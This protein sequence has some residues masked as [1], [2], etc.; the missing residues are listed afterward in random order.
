MKKNKFLTLLS[1]I[2]LASCSSTN[3]SSTTT[4]TSTDKTTT[5]TNTTTVSTDKESDT[6]LS[7]DYV[8]VASDDTS[9]A[10]E[11]SE[12]SSI[13][14]KL[15][16]TSKDDSLTAQTST[17]VTITEAGSYLFDNSITYKSISIALTSAGS[18][19]LFFDGATISGGKKA[20][21]C[22]DAFTSDITI[23]LLNNSTNTISTTKNSIDITSSL[24]INGSGT[25]NITS[26]GKSCIKS[27]KGVYLGAVTL[28]LA[29][30]ASEEGHGINASYI[31]GDSTTINVT[32]FGKD[33]LHAEMDDAVSEF[34]TSDGYI[35]LKD[36]TMTAS[37]GEGDCLQA[38][39]FINIDGGTYNLTTTAKFIAYGDSTNTT[40]YELENDDFRYTKS[41]DT[42]VKGASENA[43]RSGTYAIANSVRAFKAGGFDYVNAN[44]E[45]IEVETKSAYIQIV[46]ANITLNTQDDA[47]KCK[48]GQ[49]IVENSTFNIS[50]YD[51]GFTSDGPL[52]IN[53]STIDITTSYE[54]LEGSLI[55]IAGSKT[56][57]DIIS[58]DDGINAASDTETDLGI[59]FDN[60]NVTI[61]AD[62]DG[63]DSNGYIY[64]NYGTLTIEGSSEG[65]DSPIDSDGGYYMDGA[66]VLATGSTGMLENPQQDSKQNTLIMQASLSNG[67]KAVLKNGDNEIFTFTSSKTAGV[68]IYSSPLLK[69][70]ST[71]TLYLDDTSS[72][73]ATI[74]STIT[75]IG[76]VQQGPGQGNEPGGRPSGPG[77]S[78]P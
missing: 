41:G 36:V 57:I 27:S 18:V 43:G 52:T 14:S 55:T 15:S 71:Y 63:V 23:T 34:T 47:I 17:S 75:T 26:S 58:S 53:N 12:D 35:N 70:G 65:G 1:I 13:D 11:T 24:T 21:E 7:T 25:L 40:A 4:N 68:I 64:F 6:T 31:Y 22:E 74:S 19:H 9:Y 45:E 46:G 76:S 30:Q 8:P 56:D 39:T 20:I 32:D 5:T 42:Y 73:S 48:Y 3:T 67:T 29:A 2:L 16:D 37:N 44:E 54:G 33:A 77:P 66:T 28:N 69:T 78:R 61:N 49:I 38:D 60:G 59:I 10:I 72:G 50:T 62:G 51:Q